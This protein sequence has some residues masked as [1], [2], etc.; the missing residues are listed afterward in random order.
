MRITFIY[1]LVGVI[2]YNY[3]IIGRETLT[4]GCYE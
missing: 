1:N 2:R 3:Y 4:I